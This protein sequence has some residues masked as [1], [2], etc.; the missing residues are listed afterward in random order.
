MVDQ[1]DVDGI[2]QEQQLVGRPP[3]VVGDRL[4]PDVAAPG[5]AAADVVAGTVGAL[6]A[7]GQRQLKMAGGE[8]VGQEAHEVSLRRLQTVDRGRVHVGGVYA[9]GMRLIGFAPVSPRSSCARRPAPC[10]ARG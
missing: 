10:R 7:A 2:L 9:A 3:I 5:G 6:D 1:G 8:H 4:D